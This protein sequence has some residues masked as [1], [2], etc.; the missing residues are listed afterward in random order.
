MSNAVEHP[1]PSYPLEIQVVIKQP[2]GKY[3]G[4]NIKTDS[5][6][7]GGVEAWPV[8]YYWKQGRLLKIYT[9]D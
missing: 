2:P 6:S 9:G 8:I 4:E 5:V 3:E 1:D 7:I